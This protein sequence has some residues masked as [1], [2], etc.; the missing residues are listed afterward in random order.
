MDNKR[1]R[2]FSASILVV[3]ALFICGCAEK[4]PKRY[5]IHGTVT[6]KGE[7][8]PIGTI[9]Y[10]PDSS[11]DNSGP[12]GS[13]AIKDGK[14]DS[15]LDGK[16]FSGGPQRITIQGFDGKNPDPEFSPYGNTLGDDLYVKSFD[17]PHE[18]VELDIEMTEE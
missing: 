16:G 5:R 4:G 18:D 14:F 3:L 7:P 2:F 11:K 13:A 17:L 9:M 1:Y 12:A 8:V 10:E 15:D 6:Y